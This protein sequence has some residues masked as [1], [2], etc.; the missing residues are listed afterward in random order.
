MAKLV[1]NL[2]LENEK[3]FSVLRKVGNA[4]EK[5]GRPKEMEAFLL[6]AMRESSYSEL[7]RTAMKYVMVK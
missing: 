4:L 2:D 3:P 7:L 6:E 5:A 1:V